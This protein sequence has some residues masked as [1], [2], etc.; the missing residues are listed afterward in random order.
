MSQTIGKLTGLV[1]LYG[2]DVNSATVVLAFNNNNLQYEPA[3]YTTTTS[4]GVYSFGNIPLGA[5]F[6]VT[7]YNSTAT[8]SASVSGLDMTNSVTPYTADLDMSE[9][10]L[11]LVNYTGKGDNVKVDTTVSSIVLTFS[12]PVKSDITAAHGG[13]VYISTGSKKVFATVV[14]NANTI[15]LNLPTGLSSGTTYTIYYDVYA[16]DNK[17]ASDS[18]TF[19]TKEKGAII[20]AI[21]PQLTTVN[22]TNIIINNIPS[23]TGGIHAGTLP[24]FDVYFKPSNSDQ[25]DFRIIDP[26]GYSQSGTTTI[27]LAGAFTSGSYYVVPKATGFDGVTVYGTPSNVS[28]F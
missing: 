7:A 24:T 17:S 20:A 11:T 26:S 2:A 23:V 28:A 21:T 10:K 12:E 22:A 19:T 8:A 1:T 25:T 5:D 27:T 4:N 9:S 16:T 13:Y 15:T 6:I 14:Y 3:L 18:P